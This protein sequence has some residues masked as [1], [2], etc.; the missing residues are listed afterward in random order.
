M[1]GSSA[2]AWTGKTRGGRFGNWWFLMLLRRFGLWPAYVWLVFVAAWFTLFAGQ[3]RRASRQYLE[4]LLGPQPLWK[5]PGLVYHH[6]Y[7]MGVSLLD[8]AAVIIGRAR[9]QFDFAD[10]AEVLR[11]LAEERGV[12][13]VAAHA[14]SWEL[15][16]HLMARHGRPVNLVVLEREEQRL[17]QMFDEAL[18]AKK[19]NILTANDDPLRSIPI[20]AALRR[21]ELVALHGDRTFGS[22]ATVRL[23]F[24]GEPAS[25]PTGP[26]LLAAATGAPI[27]HV[28]AMRTKLRHYRFIA[29]PARHVPRER[30]P[31]QQTV[32]RE[33]VAEYV[34][35]LTTVL[36]QYPF[37]WYNFYP[38]WND[39]AR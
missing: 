35:H 19:F 2:T 31:A 36:K 30:G 29:F 34:D 13:L 25:F 3:E 22:D 6:F 20:V 16:G 14:G 33:C 12:I 18:R 38:F 4:R 9:M 23:P 39:N 17:R 28:F 10:E 37:Q 1:S 7:S 5:W 27:I 32:L 26:Y 21:G 11:A 8:R 24:L 15:G